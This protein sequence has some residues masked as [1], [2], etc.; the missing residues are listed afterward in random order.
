MLARLAGQGQ[1][2]DDMQKASKAKK[3]NPCRKG[4]VGQIMHKG[5]E[6]MRCLLEAGCVP[7]VKGIK[8]FAWASCTPHNDHFEVVQLSFLAGGHVVKQAQV[9]CWDAR[10]AGHLKLLQHVEY[11]FAIQVRSCKHWLQCLQNLKTLVGI[12]LPFKY[13]LQTPSDL[14]GS[15]HNI[16]CFML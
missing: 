13:A 9:D 8:D 5:Y 12:S 1:L 16:S 10:C 11:A 15:L 6:H 7:P 4:K 2:V 14:A 3:E